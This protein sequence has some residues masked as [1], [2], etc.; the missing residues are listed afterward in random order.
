MRL[1]D[2]LIIGAQKSGTTWLADQLGLHPRVFMAPDEIHFFDKASNVS[3][4]LEWYARHFERAQPGQLAGEKTPDYLWANGDGAEGHL[5]DVHLKL[6]EALPGAKLIVVLRNPVARALSALTHLVRTRR[7]AP[8]HEVDSL[9]LGKKHHLIR[10]HGVVSKGFYYRQLIAYEQLFGRSQ[11]LVLI[12]EEDIAQAPERGLDTAGAFLGIPPMAPVQSRS[13][14]QNASRRSRLRLMADY[15]FPPARP[16]SRMLDQVLP[17]W[18]PA[19]TSRTMDELEQTYL[20]ENEKLFTW[21][22]RPM[23]HSWKRAPAVSA[24]P[25]GVTSSRGPARP[26]DRGRPGGGC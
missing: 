22:G 23:P 21:L 18:K 13:V 16:V 2:F 15:Y 4:G 3:R 24:E 12:F 1:P 17:A 5:P 8:T 14:S 19:P 26:P 6:H 7:I 10:G 9:L 11:M 25:S 20:G